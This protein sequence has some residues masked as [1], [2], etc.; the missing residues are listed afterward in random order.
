MTN[1]QGPQHQ[2]MTND[3]ARILRPDARP[4]TALPTDYSRTGLHIPR[5]WGAWSWGILCRR[6][7]DRRRVR[8][9]VLR[10]RTLCTMLVNAPPSSNN[11]RVFVDNH[12]RLWSSSERVEWDI[13]D[14]R[15]SRFVKRQSET[16][17]MTSDWAGNLCL[18]FFFRGGRVNETHG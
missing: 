9:R 14:E 1:D 13:E 4:P 17:A 18:S 16:P 6:R 11:K 8:R 5:C 10:T 12:L 2:G 7:A 3:L 15:L